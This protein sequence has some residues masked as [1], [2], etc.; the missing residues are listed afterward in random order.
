MCVRM[1]VKSEVKLRSAVGPSSYSN[2]VKAFD[3]RVLHLGLFR[4]PMEQC[5]LVDGV[6]TT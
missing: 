6:D 1:S 5:H 4:L 3:A 2:L